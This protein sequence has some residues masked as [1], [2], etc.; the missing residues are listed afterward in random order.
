MLA[1][2]TGKGKTEC[3]PSEAKYRRAKTQ[4]AKWLGTDDGDTRTSDTEELQLFNVTDQ[5]RS[6]YQVDII[7][8]G[9]PLSMEIDTGAAVSIISESQQKELFPDTSLDT[10]QVELTTYTGER[11]DVVGQWNVQAQYGQQS[12]T[13]PLIVVTGDGPSL[14]GRNWLKHLRLDWKKIGKIT[15]GQDPRSIE[16]LLIKHSEIFR[17]E[18]G[19]IQPFKATLRVKENAAP[20]FYKARSVPF[21]IREAIEL[22]LN[23]LERTGILKKVDYSDW[24]APIVAVPKKDGGI[25]MWRLQGHGQPGAR[26]GPIS[27]PETGGAL[28]NAGWWQEIHKAGYVSSLPAVGS[29]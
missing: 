11:M 9:T 22:E 29:R 21:A 19:T 24:A 5:S 4:C 17:R 16:S 6:P 12:K 14:L 18:L 25:R 3:K 20:R 1:K 28:R 7:I 13:L 15:A 23:R 27:T 2:T 26:G 10:S 8:E